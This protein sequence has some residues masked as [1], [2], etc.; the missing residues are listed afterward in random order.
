MPGSAPSVDLFASEEDARCPLWFS[1]VMESTLSLGVN[2][3][4]HCPWPLGLLYTFPPVSLIPRLLERVGAERRRV[5]LVVPDIAFAR[6][7][8]LLVSLA[9]GPA[10]G[11]P[12]SPVGS[13]PGRGPGSGPPLVPG[14]ALGGLDDA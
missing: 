1:G 6:W 14:A 4:A 5:I 9:M 12:Q 11:G 3:L 13:D 7:Y 8:P 2:A 10:W